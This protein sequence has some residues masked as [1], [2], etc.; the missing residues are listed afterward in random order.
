MLEKYSL[1]NYNFSLFVFVL[2]AGIFGTI[3]INSADHSYLLKQVIGLVICMLGMI[4]LS[5]IDYK[6]ISKFYHILY[7]INIALLV[8]VSLQ[9]FLKFY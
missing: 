3:M 1:R 8:A 4:I 5:L 2:I 6:F 7:G 9:N